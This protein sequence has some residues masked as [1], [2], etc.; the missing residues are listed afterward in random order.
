MAMFAE[1]CNMASNLVKIGNSRAIIIPA[2]YLKQKGYDDKTEFEIKVT[3]RGFELMALQSIPQ[4]PK[5]SLPQEL[6][7]LVQKYSGCLGEIDQSILETDERLKAIWN[8]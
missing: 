6:S 7:P 2:K 5:V 8:R 4:L 1:N 3:D